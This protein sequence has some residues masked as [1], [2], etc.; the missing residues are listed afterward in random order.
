MLGSPCII[1]I[2]RLT[3][4]AILPP[5]KDTDTREGNWAML[6][7][8]FDLLQSSGED[9]AAFTVVSSIRKARHTFTAGVRSRSIAEELKPIESWL[10]ASGRVT[11]FLV[12]LCFPDLFFAGLRA[13]PQI[14]PRLSKYCF[15]VRPSSKPAQAGFSSN[16]SAPLIL[17]P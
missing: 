2:T 5:F 13:E 7:G 8:R 4:S 15:K 6:N 10:Q 12:A 17:I 9:T 1:S 11:C 16:P 3:L 14:A